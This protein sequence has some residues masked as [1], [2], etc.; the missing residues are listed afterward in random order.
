MM[1]E[2]SRKTSIVTTEDLTKLPLD[3]VRWSYFL[4]ANS[5]QLVI[6]LVSLKGTFS[7]RNDRSCAIPNSYQVRLLEDFDRR[8]TT[9]IPKVDV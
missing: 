7:G 4:S 6:I 8:R 1:S 3:S 9:Y 2:F 5:K